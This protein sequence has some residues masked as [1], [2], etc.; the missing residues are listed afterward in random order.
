MPHP[1]YG[2]PSHKLESVTMSLILPQQRNGFSTLLEVH[3]RASTCRT[4]LWS[5]RETWTETEQRALLEPCDQVHWLAQIACQDRPSSQ[6]ALAHS[7]SPTAWEEVPLP[8]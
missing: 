3:G 4:D 7:L 2:P 5:Y 8:F 6:E 1:I